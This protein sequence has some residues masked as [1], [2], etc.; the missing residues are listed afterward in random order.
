[1]TEVEYPLFDQLKAALV[2]TSVL[3][4]PDFTKNASFVI[5]TDASNIVIG[6]VL[7]QDEGYGLQRIAYFSQK[8]SSA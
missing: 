1:M 4:I 3:A 6:S 2:H 5:K 8:L 7:S